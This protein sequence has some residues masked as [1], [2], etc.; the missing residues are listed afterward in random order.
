MPQINYFDNYYSKPQS[1]NPSSAWSS[2]FLKSLQGRFVGMDTSTG[3]RDVDLALQQPKDKVPYEIFDPKTPPIFQPVPSPGGAGVL[4]PTDPSI[5]YYKKLQEALAPGVLKSQAQQGL[6]NLAGAGLFGL[7]QMPF[8]EYMKNKEY[9]RQLGAF[10]TKE[11]SP[12]AQSA[13]N[14]GMQQQASLASAA[15]SDRMRAY[16][17]LKR[18]IIEPLRIR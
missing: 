4:T 1:F 8:T 3:K 2:E 18:N 17:E 9:E 5:D 7:M 16:G 11:L 14:L 12:T 6:M 13:R 10:K 15:T